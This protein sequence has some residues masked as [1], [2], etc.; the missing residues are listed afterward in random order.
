MSECVASN[1]ASEAGVIELRLECTKTCLN[2]S[3]T[4]PECE[5]G[6]CQSQKLVTARKMFNVVIPFVS[7]DTAAE[8]VARQEVH[9]LRKDSFPGVHILN[10]SDLR[11][12]SIDRQNGNSKFKSIS[13]AFTRNALQQIHL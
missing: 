8:F 5:L 13:L 6:E 7:A 2:I 12:G 9:Q 4:F 1:R 11:R 3:Q 10:P